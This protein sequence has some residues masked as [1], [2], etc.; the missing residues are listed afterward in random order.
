MDPQQEGGSLLGWQRLDGLA[1]SPEPLL[2][3]Q[4][5]KGFGGGVGGA[6]GHLPLPP[7]LLVPQMRETEIHRDPIEP[8]TQAR[9]A[10]EAR[11][12]PVGAEKGLLGDIF[13]ILSIARHAIG[14]SVQLLLVL[15]DQGIEG[16]VVTLPK[17]RNQGT[18]RLV[19]PASPRW[20]VS[21]P[22]CSVRRG[23]GEDV[24]CH[25]VLGVREMQKPIQDLLRALT[26]S[27]GGRYSKKISKSREDGT[28]Q[29]SGGDPRQR[30]RLL[31]LKWGLCLLF[32]VTAC[33]EPRARPSIPPGGQ[34]GIASWYGPKFHGRRTAS[35]EVFD[36]H[37]L[38]AAHRTLPLGSWVQVTN[39]DNGRSIPVRVNDRGPF[40]GGRI[41]DLSYA[42]ARVLDMVDDGLAPVH[43]V[44]LR[45]PPAHLVAT[46][47]AY[48]LQVGSFADE[49]NARALKA[50]LDA[51]TAGG[52]VSAVAAEGQTFYR[53]RVGRYGSREAAMQAATRVASHGLTVV[54][55]ESD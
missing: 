12:G 24:K 4:L 18:I 17:S 29:K 36:M 41:I 54:L 3:F 37:Q 33:A 13:G 35:G 20:T 40:V 10:I 14:Q 52:Y 45:T 44:L 5:F 50:R 48:T 8:R 34:T 47:R 1:H 32:L 6:L 30:R 9:A 46:P 53:V 27:G 19:H 22:P 38:S 39:L 55:M 15:A 43:I 25:D 7:G 11:E 28:V 26:W 42:S 23:R 51:V 2:R 16:G 49:R 21:P 31:G